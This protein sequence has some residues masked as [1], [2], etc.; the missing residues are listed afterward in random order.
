[1]PRFAFN[2]WA[3]VILGVI[4]VLFVIGGLVVSSSDL[5]LAGAGLCVV[6][7]VGLI[8]HFNAR[9]DNGQG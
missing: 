2:I 1:M 7:G 3:F 5:L 8:P 9:Y 6:S 4:G